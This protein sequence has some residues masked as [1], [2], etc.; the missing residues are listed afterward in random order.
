M[1]IQYPYVT[2]STERPAYEYIQHVTLTFLVVPDN[3]VPK[4]NGFREMLPEPRPRVAS[5]NWSEA[6]SEGG[7][8]IFIPGYALLL[9]SRWIIEPDH[10][11]AG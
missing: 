11:G 4:V 8:T 7:A 5:Y 3:I 6:E 10:A 1:Y 9:D 2:V